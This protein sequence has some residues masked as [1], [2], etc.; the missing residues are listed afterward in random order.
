MCDKMTSHLFRMN[1]GPVVYTID[2]HSDTRMALGI[3]DQDESYC[4]VEWCKGSCEPEI[5]F[6]ASWHDDQR[7]YCVN[8]Y[9]SHM[10]TRDAMMR[11]CV[12]NGASVQIVPGEE[13]VLDGVHA[14]PKCEWLYCRYCIGLTS[15]PAL[16]ECKALN[17]PGCTG[18]TSLPE[19]LKCRTLNCPGC[20]GL[21]SLPEL[22]KCTT[23]YCP[24]CTGLT[25][26]PELL[27]CTTLYCYGC[28]GLTSLPELLKCKWIYCGDCTG[29]TSLPELLKC[30]TLYCDDRLR[31]TRN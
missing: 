1:D 3:G 13:S 23:L 24:G 6:P 21:T 28:T 22:L 19:L 2:S 8:W 26:L 12:L 17:C 16:P 20:T 4:D 18:L 10:P 30:T 5:R 29:L 9:A 7:E 31:K 25:S 27:K 11:W 14:L 15:L